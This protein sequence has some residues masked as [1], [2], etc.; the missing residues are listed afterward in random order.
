MANGGIIGPVNPAGFTSKTSTFNATGCFTRGSSKSTAVNVLVVAG[1]G[2][3]G[4]NQGGGAGAGGYRFC[5]S[6][7]ITCATYKV[8][9]G[10]G[11][12]G[13]VGTGA[14]AKIHGCV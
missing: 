14:N 3:G 6:Y 12:S 1:G 10:A 5:E 8:T 13:S 9:V 7:T 4:G 2:G 11:G